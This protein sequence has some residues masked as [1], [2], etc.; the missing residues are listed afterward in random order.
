MQIPGPYSQRV[1]SEG[2]SIYRNLFLGKK[3]DG[4]GVGFSGSHS[5]TADPGQ[6]HFSTHCHGSN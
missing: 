4:S 5:E 6:G 3:P 2:L 1:V